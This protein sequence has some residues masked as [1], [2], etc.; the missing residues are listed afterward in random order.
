MKKSQLFSFIVLLFI[1]SFKNV[2][3]QKDS[4]G[5]YLTAYDFSVKKLSYAINCKTEKHKI[6]LNDFFGKDYIT[7]IHNSIKYNLSKDSVFGFKT[8]DG[9]T[10]RLADKVEYTVLNPND[11]LLFYQFTPLSTPKNPREPVYKFSTGS[12]SVLQ[13]LTI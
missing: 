3:A 6:K 13:D 10:Y 1:F 9:N 2:H 4:S 11:T 8:C 5:V 7:V 12:S